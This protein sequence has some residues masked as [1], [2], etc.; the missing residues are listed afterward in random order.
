MIENE[1]M[2]HLDPYD[3]EVWTIRSLQVQPKVRLFGWF[4]R[5]RQFV[6]IHGKRRDDLERGPRGPKWDRAMQKVVT[7]RSQLFPGVVP[8][9]GYTFS[10]YV[11]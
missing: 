2:K 7:A 1:D 8:Y 3:K 5:P 11:G 4:I 6:V 9:S 10:D